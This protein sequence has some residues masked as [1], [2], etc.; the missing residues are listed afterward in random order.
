MSLS[1]AP[2][3]D[4]SPEVLASVQMGAALRLLELVEELGREAT[5]AMLFG[6][7]GIVLI[8]KG[9]LCWATAEGMRHRLTDL[10]RLGCSPPLEAAALEN[11]YLSCKRDGVPI[12]ER[13]VSSGLIS[14]K[15]LRSG[16]RQHN[17]EALAL[18]SASGVSHDFR[19]HSKN[20][21]DARFTFS[22]VEL[23]A[24]IGGLRFPAEAAWAKGH[25]RSVLPERAYAVAVMQGGGFALPLPIAC[26]GSAPLSC[27]ELLEVAQWGR[28]VLDVSQVFSPSCKIASGT[29][30]RH[31]SAVSWCCGPASY[32]ALCADRTDYARLLGRLQDE[33]ARGE[34][35]Y[36][37]DPESL[38][39]IAERAARQ[40]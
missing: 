27:R 2:R 38:Q 29:D 39:L 1:S 35:A 17:A 21:Y 28:S 22:T 6:R 23:L 32:V 8:E 4:P 34:A 3:V 36:S 31:G 24:S 19:A 16:L 14:A 18:I 12:G 5:G 33:L 7:N 37:P 40:P 11:V 13:L 26:S 10:L 20:R 9:L 25:L 30:H 15:G